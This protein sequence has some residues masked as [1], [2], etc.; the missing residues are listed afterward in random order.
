MPRISRPQ[1]G[2]TS[3]GDGKVAELVNAVVLKTA[4]IKVVREFESHP[5]PE[6]IV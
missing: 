2:I 1:G 4:A 3:V 6:I 5:F